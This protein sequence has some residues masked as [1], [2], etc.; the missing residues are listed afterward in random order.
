MPNSLELLFDLLTN[1]ERDDAEAE[2]QEQ[3]RE[4]DREN[5]KYNGEY[6]PPN[7]DEYDD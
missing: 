2:I 3:R 5:S 7:I 6:V 1:P 4:R